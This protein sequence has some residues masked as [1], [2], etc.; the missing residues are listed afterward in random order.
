MINSTISKG[1]QEDRK[2]VKRTLLRM[3]PEGLFTIGVLFHLN[4]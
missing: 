1:T 3:L 4:I 2:K